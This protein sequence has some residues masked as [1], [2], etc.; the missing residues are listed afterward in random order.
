MKKTKLTSNLRSRHALLP[1]HRAAPGRRPA[2]RQDTEHRAA[3]RTTQR[4]D[5][6]TPATRLP[7]YL[8]RLFFLALTRPFLSHWYMPSMAFKPWQFLPFP[9]LA[10]SL[11]LRSY[12]AETAPTELSLPCPSSPTP[13]P[14]S[15][16]LAIVVRGARRSRATSPELVVRRR[17][18]H[19]RLSLNGASP[20]PTRCP[21]FADPAVPSPSRA[22]EPVRRRPFTQGWRQCQN[23]NLFSKACIELI[24]EFVNYRCNIDAIWRFTYMILEISMYTGSQNWTPQHYF[25]YAYDF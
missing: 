10:L 24:Y 21:S 1:R 18:V 22:L 14:L 15:P 17:T 6:R 11:P 12:K 9:S 8:L 19:A 16:S 2:H 4:R 5:D 20:V 3:N 23:I 25:E 13:R 7:G